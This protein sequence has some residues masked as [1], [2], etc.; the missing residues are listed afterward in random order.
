VVDAMAEL[1]IGHTTHD[2]ARIWIRGDRKRRFARVTLEA[3]KRPIPS[4]PIELSADDDFTGATS[5]G[6]LDPATEY[7]VSARFASTRRRLDRSG[8]FLERHGRLR[9]FP[10]PRSDAPFSFLLGSC[11]LS[12]VTLS[13]LGSLAAGGGGVLAAAQSLERQVEGRAV[14]K[15]ALALADG[16][17]RLVYAAW[18]ALQVVAFPLRWL[19]ARL[20]RKDPPRPPEWNDKASLVY[21]TFFLVYKRSGFKLKEPFLPKPFEPLC[22]VVEK[23]LAD[24][25]KE[26]H[27]HEAAA[28]PP[29][30][31]I[32]A[33]DQIYFDIPFPRRVPTLAAYR[34]AYREAWFEDPSLRQ[35]LTR[36]PQFMILDDHDIVDGF[37]LDAPGL[38]HDPLEY[39]EPAKRAYREYVDAQRIDARQPSPEDSFFYAF[40]HGAS[41]FFVLDT[42]THRTRGTG[43]MIDRKQMKCFQKW[44][45]DH[46]DGVKF[47][48][49]SIP[50]VAEVSNEETEASRR[51]K[52]DQEDKWSGPV[53]RA[54]REEILRFLHENRMGRV[55]FLVGDMHCCY[56][57]SM[58]IGWP[59]DRITVHELAGGP[60]YQLQFGGRERFMAQHRGFVDSDAKVP[61]RTSLAQLH[62]SASGVLHVSV[63]TGSAPEIRWQVVRTSPDMKQT[64]KPRPLSGRIRFEEQRHL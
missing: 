23:G 31:M 2:A 38:P 26:G 22:K 34:L 64:F 24:E 48:V 40:D 30:F 19:R 3:A 54:Q 11:N 53:F 10:E 39:L 61:F 29:A 7:T 12:I 41:H 17:V 8:G 58:R 63:A 56:H 51:S 9:T 47:V 36:C 32:H 43:E 37:A 20:A 55:V 25:V 35:L 13:N 50:F 57:A 27:A 52:H 59:H 46:P 44:L 21:A 45:L 62:G 5:I 28:P 6:G 49:S 33:G 1:I 4:G 16:L 42:R 14:W 18:L 60:V 15:L